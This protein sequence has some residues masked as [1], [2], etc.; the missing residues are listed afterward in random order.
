MKLHPNRH[1]EPFVITLD[2]ESL[3]Y[4][5]DAVSR[6]EDG[7]TAFVR[8]ACPGDQVTA[9]IT[10]DRGRFVRATVREVLAASPDRVGAPCP[11]FG[12]CGGCQWQHISYSLQLLSKRQSVVDALVRIGKVTDADDLV[13]QTIASPAEYGYRNKAE[14]VPD[15]H[16]QRLALGFHKAASG[17]VVPV[18]ACLLLP[19]RAQKAPRAL[20]GALRYVAGDSPLGISRVTVRV[21]RHTKDLEI[22]VWTPPGAFPRSLSARTLGQALSPTSL[23]RVMHKGPAEERSVSKVEV[24]A[25][26]GQWR[27]KLGVHEYLVS[28]PSFFQVNTLAAEQMVGLVLEELDPDG[29]DRVLD[30]YAGVGTFTL[31][32]AERAGEVTAVESHGPA[33]RDLRR[34]LEVNATWAEVVGGDAAREI[35]ALGYFDLILVDPPR[36]GVTSAVLDAI[37]AA[38]P[39]VLIYV[40]CDPTTLARDAKSLASA[41]MRLVSATPVDLFPQT[42]HVETVAR[43]E[44]G[45]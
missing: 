5:G 24:L 28:A 15:A 40:S 26:K 3:A 38:R 17:E 6:L 34:N 27:E 1:P 35:G 8:G 45:G 19:K 20:S 33:V 21:A 13:A 4:G 12:S 10:E 31:P 11:Y 16:A 2:I 41:G 7:R 42:F 37:A 43:F 39:R 9:E 22:A 29:T 23:V 14:L 32:L 18:D 44:Q 36:A 25:G 30:L